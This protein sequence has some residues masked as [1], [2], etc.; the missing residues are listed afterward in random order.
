[1]EMEYLQAH[2]KIVVRS[3]EEAIGIGRQ[4]A[5]VQDHPG[6]AGVDGEVSLGDFWEGTFRINGRRICRRKYNR[7]E[8]DRAPGL[9]VGQTLA[10][11]PGPAVSGTGHQAGG[12]GSGLV[13]TFFPPNPLSPFPTGEGG[14]KGD[15]SHVGP[16]WMDLRHSH[17]LTMVWL[18]SADPVH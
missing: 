2:H 14:V 9:C 10:Q 18:N 5:A 16:R 8:L 17:I 1:M 3:D 13:Q 12:A 6:I 7:I 15:R 4:V 11:R